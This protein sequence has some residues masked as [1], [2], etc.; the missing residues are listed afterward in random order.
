MTAFT[1]GPMKNPMTFPYLFAMAADRRYS[2]DPCNTHGMNCTDPMI[3]YLGGPGGKDLE[4]L[5]CRTHINVT[6]ITKMHRN[7]IVAKRKVNEKDKMWTRSLNGHMIKCSIKQASQST[8]RQVNNPEE[9][10]L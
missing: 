2:R 3:G 10:P 4:S 1:A 7:I 9:C 8:W 5:R 6:N